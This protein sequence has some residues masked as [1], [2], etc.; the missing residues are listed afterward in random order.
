MEAV[1]TSEDQTRALAA[2]L[3]A[4]LRPGDV[5]LLFGELGAGKTTFV[6]GLARGLEV[7]ED[8]YVQSPTFAL[9]NEYPGRVPLYHV[10]LYRLEPEEAYDLGLEELVAQGVVAIEWPE[11][12]PFS[13]GRREI[14][15]YL[16]VLAPEKRKIKIEVPHDL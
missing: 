13:L 12:L 11:K 10:D 9:I 2:K 4:K 5:V 1:T 16:E 6:K 14:K 8:Y 15:V 3:G 7:P